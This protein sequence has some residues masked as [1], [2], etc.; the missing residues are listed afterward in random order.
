VA[1]L[2]T[3][4]AS[5]R[6]AAAQSSAPPGGAQHP[7]GAEDEPVEIEPTDLAAEP[8]WAF[9]ARRCSRLAVEIAP[10]GSTA[11]L[12]L[13]RCGPDR[14]QAADLRGALVRLGVTAGLDHAA[15]DAALRRATDHGVLRD[16]TVIA[17]A[18]APIPGDDGRLVY[19]P[20]A[21]DG[22]PTSGEDL[23]RYMGAADVREAL[24]FPGEVTLVQPG[25]V[26]AEVLPP[27]PG[28]P[29]ETVDGRVLE[30][31]G[32]QLDPV[33]PGAQVTLDGNRYLANSFGYACQ[34]GGRPTVL[35]PVWV[36][37]D[38]L[39]ARLVIFPQSADAQD[40]VAPDAVMTALAAAGVVEGILEG[41]VL[42]FCVKP[43]GTR[44]HAL[45]VARGRAAREG[46]DA[47]IDLAFDLHSRPGRVR[48]DGSIDFRDRNL[49]VAVAADQVI[50]T[51]VAAMPGE[52][53]ITV[54][55]QHLGARDGKPY[56]VTAGENVRFDGAGE[57]GTY[58]ATADGAARFRA[59][60]LDVLPVVAV[61]GDVGYQTGHID[62][63]ADVQIKGSVQ[64]GFRVRSEGNVLIQGTVD[65]GA[66][67]EAAGDVGVSLGIV[68]AHT[69]VVAAGSVECK[70]VQNSQVIA[71]GDIRVSSYIANAQVHAG[72]RLELSSGRGGKIVGGEVFGGAA[73]EADS[74]GSAGGEGTIVGLRMS[75]LVSAAAARL[76]AQIAA[77][78]QIIDDATTQLGVPQLDAELVRRAVDRAPAPAR[79]GLY[80]VLKEAHRC[81]Q[82]LA[83]LETELQ[84]LKQEQEGIA[85]QGV[86]LVRRRIH[87]DTIVEIGDHRL[88]LLQALGTCRFCLGE[89]GIEERH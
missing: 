51:L 76:A 28:T 10:D 85:R 68:G 37:P 43:P 46:R 42:R 9:G 78:R 67:V 41:P 65:N 7:Q 74:L 4:A 81:Q 77:H 11:Q 5:A 87:A 12:A 44:R 20:A 72:G 34:V 36:S 30:T 54:R 21:R 39:E 23:Q 86:I 70:F 48:E 88:R 35:S 69:R 3:P 33:A 56:T 24:S 57:N 1:A 19:R 59:D 50:G 73:L 22:R 6:A 18:R 47:H 83:T 62:T 15:I 84:T 31:P 49:I 60:R 66:L 14:P 61:G 29:G 71:Q 89:N 75:P 8:V 26:V 25:D 55:G 17:R 63:Q 40:P 80:E 16:G 82:E 13:L 53:G 27:T 58:V 32:R 2:A 79:P 52:P 45:L 38:E 64:A